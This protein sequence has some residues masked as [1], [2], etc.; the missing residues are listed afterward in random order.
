LNKSSDESNVALYTGKGRGKKTKVICSGCKKPGH[1]LENCWIAH[2]E[3][4]KEFQDRKKA[5]KDS[6]DSKDSNSNSKDEGLSLYLGA[7]MSSIKNEWLVDTGATQ[8]ISNDLKLFSFFQESNN[9]PKIMTAKGV[10]KPTGSRSVPLKL[11]N[12]KGKSVFITL[13]NVHYT[14]GLPT[15]LFL[16]TVIQRSNAYICG[17]TD[18]LRIKQDNHEIAALKV[19]G[20]SLFLDQDQDQNLDSL[21]PWATIASIKLSM[22]L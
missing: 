3:K 4:K 14:L 11:K 18:T 17:K 21:L 5:K 1:E 15:N 12:T 19:I 8:H 9:L 16:G 22:K 7:F 6:K 20:E 2:P 13:V 10:I